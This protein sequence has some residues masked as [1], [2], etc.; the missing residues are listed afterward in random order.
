MLPT[1]KSLTTFLI[2]I[3][4]SLSTYACSCAGEQSFCN[5]IQSTYFLNNGGII[6][7]AESTGNTAGDYDFRAFEMKLIDLM[8]GTIQPGSGTYENA[9]STFWIILGQSA[10]CYEGIWLGNEGD[11]FVMAP[12]Y[13]ELFTF[14]DVTEIGYSLFL[15]SHDVFPYQDTMIGPIINDTSFYP[16]YV[17]AIDTV[18]S[19]QLPKIVAECTN[20]LL[21]WDLSGMH[22]TP[23]VYQAGSTITSSATVN[24]NVLYK[25]G[26]RVRL[27]TDF[28]TNQSINF[29]VSIDGCN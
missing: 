13:G 21:N 20:C 1:M 8:Y 27:G 7:L 3:S 16:D 5:H 29:G 28:K 26:D 25:A 19:I 24:A 11:Q 22:N 12:I 23:F 10:T 4:F 18:S 14:T 6:C 2:F 17:W 15:C 9:D